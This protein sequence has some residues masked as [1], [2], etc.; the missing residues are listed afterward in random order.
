MISGSRSRAVVLGVLLGVTLAGC[1]A[2]GKR[3]GDDL[4]AGIRDHD[5]PATVAQALPAYLVLL[6]GLI[7]SRPSQV[8]LLRAAAELYAVYAGSFVDDVER[9]RRLSAR[10]LDYARRA[11]C[12][13][14]EHWC[15]RLD[16]PVDAFEQVVE[17]A[18][19]EDADELF[20][21]GS[22]WAGQIQAHSD[23]FRA[24]A[25]L[26]KAQALID[27][28]IALEPGFR[29]GMPH[30]YQGVL[31]SLRP[32]ALGGNPDSGREAFEE[33]LRWSDGRNLMA[34]TLQAEFHARL[35]FDR[36][37]HDSLLD[38]ALSM[39]VEAPGLTLSNVL[40]QQRAR[41]LREQADAYF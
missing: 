10:A 16:G 31:L 17:Q 25:N 40:A 22:A 37:L 32:P 24:I 34:L 35:V 1:A 30:V 27:R 13:D 4:A 5:D 28:V 14:R 36:A 29:S 33:A 38:R 15:A 12:V 41:Q 8:N 9:T 19:V 39:P 11:T 7:A 2:L 26:P 23:D 20:N 6:D 21:L 3:V 18:S